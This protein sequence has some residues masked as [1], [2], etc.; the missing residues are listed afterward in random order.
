MDCQRNPTLEE[1]DQYAAREMELNRA[2]QQQRLE[3]VDQLYR[4]EIEAFDAAFNKLVDEGNFQKY[5]IFTEKFNL[6]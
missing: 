5:H 1:I 6:P 3:W 4:E 2:Q